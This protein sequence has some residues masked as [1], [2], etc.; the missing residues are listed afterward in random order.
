MLL[1]KLKGMLAF[2][3]SHPHQEL[4]G[5]R[6]PIFFGIQ[7]LILG[8][9]MI[10]VPLGSVL[11]KRDLWLPMYLSIASLITG[12]LVTL[13]MPETLKR[14]TESEPLISHESED[15]EPSKDG[16]FVTN[17]VKVG[18]NAV[19]DFK[20]LFTSSLMI[21]LIF[22]FLVNN[23]TYL[24]VNLYLQYASRRYHWTIGEVSLTFLNDYLQY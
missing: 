12:I 11:M 21:A 17:F 8:T 19:K 22:T 18:I 20:V 13:P 23:L 16:N 9:Q 1:M 15:D 5:H 6:T 3:N 24:F 14:D 4:T 10:A 2:P 7:A